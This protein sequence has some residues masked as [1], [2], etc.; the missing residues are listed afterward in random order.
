MA[1]SGYGLAGLGMGKVKSFNQY[2][3]TP[4]FGGSAMCHMKQ[5]S[6]ALHA[7]DAASRKKAPR[8]ERCQLPFLVQPYFLNAGAASSVCS[9]SA[10][11][12]ISSFAS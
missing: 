6:A 10:N 5:L 7:A 2:R 4:G 11:R 3:L 1:E 9:H 12:R 8:P